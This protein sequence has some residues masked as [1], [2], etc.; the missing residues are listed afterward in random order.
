MRVGKGGRETMMRGK[1]LNSEAN[2][3]DYLL[4]G[5]IIMLLLLGELIFENQIFPVTNT[6]W[7][8][9]CGIVVVRLDGD[10]LP[11]NLSLF[12]SRIKRSLFF[13][14]SLL[15]SDDVFM[16]PNK[17]I[18]LS[19]GFAATHGRPHSEGIKFRVPKA[20]PSPPPAK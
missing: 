10:F 4:S 9:A 12:H 8:C 13:S 11:K 6:P 14:L 2:Q 20:P 5:P 19:C 18:P 3:G 15:E 16:A 1:R 17:M 7:H